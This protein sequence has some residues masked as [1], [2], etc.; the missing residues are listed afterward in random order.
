VY[1]KTAKVPMR[2][3]DDRVLGPTTVHR[4]SYSTAKAIDEHLAFAYASNRLPVVIVRYFNSYGPRLD[5]RG[6]GS[7]VANFLR[8]ALAGEPLTVHGDGRQSRCFTYIDDTVRGTML[9]GFTTEAE[10][11]IFNLGSTAET[12]IVELAEMIKHA[13][14]SDSPGIRRHA[15]TGPRHLTR[16]RA[17]RLGAARGARRRPR[18]HDRMV[19]E[20]PC[21]RRAVTSRRASR[22]TRSSSVSWAS[23]T[24]VFPCRSRSR[25]LAFEVWGS[26]STPS[27]PPR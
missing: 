21:L 14:G 15:S 16:A 4:W 11:Q 1:G 18:P 12:T 23:A 22:R 8:Q 7:V 17:A 25:S 5:E 13:V 20:D 26:T 10:G 2:E 27:A 3:D 6:Y 19:G 9:A 24:S